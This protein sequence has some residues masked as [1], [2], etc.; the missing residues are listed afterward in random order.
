MVCCASSP[1]RQSRK[2]RQYRPRRHFRNLRSIRQSLPYR[3]S[4][5]SSSNSK[6]SRLRSCLIAYRAANKFGL[7]PKRSSPRPRKISFAPDGFRF[8]GAHRAR[9]QVP[10]R[11]WGPP[12]S[13]G[14]Q[15]RWIA[16]WPN[17]P[18]VGRVS[19]R[20]QPRKGCKWPFK[21]LPAVSFRRSSSPWP[22]RYWRLVWQI[23]IALF[24]P[25]PFHRPPISSRFKR[26][27]ASTVG[28]SIRRIR[29]S[30]S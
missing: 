14:H 27:C 13:V 5:G 23:A 29:V 26:R 7:V 19:F 28:A 11:K 12:S 9:P 17:R 10:R 22:T 15:P 25:Q 2:V 4:R 1:N 24:L 8:S 16:S 30:S 6:S 3:K 21:G 20:A 18:V